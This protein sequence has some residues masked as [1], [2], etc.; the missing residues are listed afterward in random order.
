[1]ELALD[2]VFQVFHCVGEQSQLE[3]HLLLLEGWA[4]WSWWL[5]RGA[6]AARGAGAILTVLP[7]PF[8]HVSCGL[9]GGVGV[10]R[11]GMREGLFVLE[12]R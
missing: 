8:G 7:S 2:V 1:M 9:V 5:R 4:W 12:T 10:G 3:R 11:L 6:A